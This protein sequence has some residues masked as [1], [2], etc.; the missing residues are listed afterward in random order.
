MEKIEVF[1]LKSVYPVE[2]VIKAVAKFLNLGYFYIS[3]ND[4]NWIVNIT[5]KGSNDVETIRYEFNNELL[6]QVVRFCVYKNTK[7]IREMLLARAISTSLI[8]NEPID[9]FGSMGSQG[10]TEEELKEILTDWFDN[11]DR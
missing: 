5:A 3:E 6:A 11:D 2:C 4:K 10:I 9:N 1:V 7:T 8:S